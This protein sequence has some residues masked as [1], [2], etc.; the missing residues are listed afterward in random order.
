MHLILQEDDCSPDSLESFDREFLQI[1]GK[2]RTEW[3]E[4]A[5]LVE[6]GYNI[7]YKG[8]GYTLTCSADS[9]Y[10]ELYADEIL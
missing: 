8:N 4:S 6:N 2:T 1:T 9:P 3:K 10:W 7:T 5:V